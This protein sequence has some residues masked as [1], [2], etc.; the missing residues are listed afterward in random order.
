MFAHCN[1]RCSADTARSRGCAA[2]I[3]AVLC[4]AAGVA[5][6]QTTQPIA[7]PASADAQPAQPVRPL[8]LP[9]PDVACVNR[10]NV[11]ISYAVADNSAPPTRAEVW[12]TLDHGR[13]WHKVPHAVLRKNDINFEVPKDGL[14]GFFVILENEGGA[15][16][17]PPQPGTGP[18]Q[19]LNVDQTAPLVQILQV[20]PD[21]QFALNRELTIRW[22]INDANLGDRP[23]TIH[24][25]TQ[26][27]KAYRRLV[28]NL[29]PTGSHSWTVP[30]H[31]SGRLDLRIS[32]IDEAG[33]TGT[34][35]CDWLRL[36]ANGVV[37]ARPRHARSMTAGRIDNVPGAPTHQTETR[38]RPAELRKRPRP[39]ENITWDDFEPLP[40]ELR[41]HHSDTKSNADT[42]KSQGAA[43]DARNRYDLGTWHRLR[44][45]HAVAVARFREALEL[46]PDLIPARNDLAA[47][48]YLR[49]DYETAKREYQRILEQDPRHLSALKGLA[50]V[51]AKLRNFHSASESLEKILMFAPDDAEAWLHLGDTRLFMGDRAGAREAWTQA[52]AL[53]TASEE[54][55]ERARRRLTIY[56]ADGLDLAPAR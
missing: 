29:P 56:R 42:N 12:Y 8:H 49:G 7:D 20:R 18:Q 2:L 50:V 27:T 28:E 55:K 41:K 11:R 44:G 35:D 45:E 1:S 3:V 47:L 38:I 6:A 51:E 40:A 19:W 53:E 43:D 10:G 39:Q 13:T 31:L 37:D 17:P 36:V 32:A 30:D 14:Y 24:Y 33:N 9:P 54:I 23:V 25:R 5:I 34:T 21:P 22:N 4:L 26:Q 15:S 46:D 52:E 48:L 16:S